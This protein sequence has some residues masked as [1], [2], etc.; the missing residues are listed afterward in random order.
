MNKCAQSCPTLCDPLTVACQSPLYIV[1]SRQEYWSGLPGPSPRDLPDPGI[2]PR[3]PT[4]QADY[5]PSEPLGKP[6]QTN[7]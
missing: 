1:V 2:E 4:L 7:K 6:R 3:S 5:L